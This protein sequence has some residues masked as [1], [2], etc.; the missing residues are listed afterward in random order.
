M[1][2]NSKIITALLVASPVFAYIDQPCDAGEWGRGVCV[3]ASDCVVYDGQI[4][5]SHSYE[6]SAPNWPCP[7]DPD[8]VMCCAKTVT[9]LRDGRTK[10]SG[11]C[12]NISECTTTSIPSWECPGSQRVQLCVD[13]EQPAENTNT[14]TNTNNKNDNKNNNNNNGNKNDNKVNNINEIN[15]KK[16]NDANILQKYKDRLINNKCKFQ[17][18]QFN[19]IHPKKCKGKVVKGL[20]PGGSDNECC[21]TVPKKSTNTCTFEGKEYNCMNPEKCTGDNTVVSGLCPGG[22]DNK[23]CVPKTN[24][25]YTVE[26][27]PKEY[28]QYDP[29]F[30]DYPYNYGCT[31]WNSG[32]LITA[33]TNAY[34]TREHTTLTPAQYAEDHMSFSGCGANWPYNTDN[35]SYYVDAE[36]SLHGI[37]EGLKIGHIVVVG[38]GPDE[39]HQHWVA[40]NSWIGNDENNLQASDFLILDPGFDQ[41]TLEGHFNS[42]PGFRQV[43]Y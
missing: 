13:A 2:F 10:K 29:A 26:V 35:E 38:S 9:Q 34:N 37:L 6:G 14:N 31:I 43:L 32:C 19:C 21:I 3:K 18:N 42:F 22:A 23:C 12:L 24:I 28:K 20:C 1:H 4:G 25:K 7:N 40:V 27:Y 36:K 39:D 17:G 5:E 8:D 15:E 30:R 11:R 33:F 16:K 41:T